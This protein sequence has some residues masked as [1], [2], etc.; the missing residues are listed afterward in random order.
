MPVGPEGDVCNAVAVVHQR[1]DAL[2]LPRSGQ[3]AP[4]TN[5]LTKKKGDKVH[6]NS[7]CAKPTNLDYTSQKGKMQTHEET[8]TPKPK[9]RVVQNKTNKHLRT[10]EEIT[11][12]NRT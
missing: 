11:R 3:L 5:R 2:R 7:P 12:E 4:A 9:P 10:H 6:H 1:V 8:T